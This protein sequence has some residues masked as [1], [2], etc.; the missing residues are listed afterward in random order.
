MEEYPRSSPT[1]SSSTPTGPTTI[2]VS[3]DEAVVIDRRSNA[4]LMTDGLNGCVAVAL[5]SGDRIGLT[6]VYSDALDRFEDYKAPLAAFARE[7]ANGGGITDAYLVHNNNARRLGEEHNL[8]EMIREHL[9]TANL[10]ARSAV[11]MLPDNGCTIS[12]NGLYFK[13]LDN[14]AIFKSGGHTNSA[15]DRLD[16]R[17]AATIAPLRRDDLFNFSESALKSGYRGPSEVAAVPIE[18]QAHLPGARDQPGL[19]CKA[20]PDHTKLELSESVRVQLAGFK[21]LMFSDIRPASREITAAIKEQGLTEATLALS[22]DK[23]HINVTGS[24]KSVDFDIEGRKVRL[25]APSFQVES[26]SSPSLPSSS[27]SSMPSAT[28]A[29]AQ[30]KSLYEQATAALAPHRDSL[31]L[32][33]PDRFSEAARTIASQANRDG[34]ADIARVEVLGTEHGKSVLVA[35][36]G[37]AEPKHSQPTVVEGAPQQGGTTPHDPS[38]DAPQKGHFTIM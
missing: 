24:G 38:Q 16:E 26:S 20:P 5:R 3:L 29:D 32:G 4:E 27:M 8:P 11:T 7:V 6:H 14:Q 22:D 12:D 15:L 18:P 21:V 19:S 34:L 28:L 17:V 30:P 23:K 1:A 31:K 33:D 2:K 25:A 9:V 36:Q 10:V 35:H 13:H 37:G